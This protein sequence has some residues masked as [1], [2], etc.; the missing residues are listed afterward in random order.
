LPVV[1]A[2]HETTINLIAWGRLA[3]LQHP[4]QMEQLRAN[5]ALMVSAI[6]ELLR[7][8]NPLEMATTRFAREHVTIAG[9]TIP[10]GTLGMA[11]QASANRDAKQFNEPDRPNLTRENNPQLAFGLGAHFCLGAPLAR[12]EGQIANQQASAKDAEV[13]TGNSSRV[14]AVADDAC[15]ARARGPA[16]KS[17]GIRGSVTSG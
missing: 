13:A 3:L 7:F 9:T 2:G 6:E 1:I 5:P 15:L 12:R 11:V 4:D 16:P 14:A 17:S 8:S 10:R